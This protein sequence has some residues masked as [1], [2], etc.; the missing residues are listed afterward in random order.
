MINVTPRRSTGSSSLSA[1]D[2]GLETNQLNEA[3]LLSASP[4]P[5]IA[6]AQDI[7]A[8]WVQLGSDILT[9]DRMSFKG[10]IVVDINDAENVRIRVSA[11]SE[12]GGL[13]G[14]FDPNKIRLRLSTLDATAESYFELDVDADDT[15]IL[16]VDLDGSTPAIALYVQAGT[17]GATAGQIDE[18]EYVLR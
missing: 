4:V 10:W 18:F 1:E 2:T 14:Y 7:T 9:I 3:F 8:S 6:A 16:E 17:A 15:Y 13:E 5:L 12:V 11:L